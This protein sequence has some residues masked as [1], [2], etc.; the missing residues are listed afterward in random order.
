MT[1]F[2]ITLIIIFATGCTTSQKDTPGIVYNGLATIK[3]SI[4]NLTDTT[5]FYCK[6]T[7]ILPNGCVI[8]KEE[9]TND[10]EYFYSYQTTIPDHIEFNIIKDFQTYI[11]PG[12]TLKIDA[13]F[14][15]SLDIE[16]AVTIDGIYGDISDYYEN[17]SKRFGYFDVG[18]Q[19]SNYSNP[20]VTMERAFYLS[21]SILQNE[22]DFLIAYRKVKA[23]PKWFCD[24]IIMDIEYL[25]I[26][27]R[28]VLITYRKYFFKEDIANP[29]QY[30]IFDQMPV[31]NPDAR[32]SKLYYDCLDTYFGI[33]HED[34]METSGLERMMALI[35]RSIPEAKKE[36]KGDVLEYYL[37]S[38]LSSII[39][40]CRQKRDM[41]KVDTLFNSVKLLISNSE[42]VQMLEFERE[43]ISE[44]INSASTD[45]PFI[46]SNIMTFEKK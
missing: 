2:V 33:K 21:D 6:A 37:A 7:P 29:E 10:G 23:L 5:T 4:K 16:S 39:L 11:V 43:K 32:L 44:F 3:L 41:E 22:K 27:I 13:N 26:H 1:K 17:K 15:P 31:Y 20:S 14:D 42:A 35:E 40:S 25:K 12:D 34:L 28:P 36:L 30:Y 46:L 45:K 24:I 38:R 8:K 18:S 9:I 19:L